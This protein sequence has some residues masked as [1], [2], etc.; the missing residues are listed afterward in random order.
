MTG[1][2]HST[3]AMF[4]EVQFK[5][6]G[7]VA[8]D[9]LQSEQ[10]NEVTRIFCPTFGSSIFGENTGMPAFLTNLLGLFDDSSAF[11]PVVTFDTQPGW[12]PQ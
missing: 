7:A 1:A 12:N 5:V 11:K 8:N 9:S 2:G 6:R 3:G 10:G 4:A